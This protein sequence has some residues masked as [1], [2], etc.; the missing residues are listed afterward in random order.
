MVEIKCEFLKSKLV[1]EKEMVNLRKRWMVLFWEIKKVP[2]LAK[3]D[4]EL[5]NQ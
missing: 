4:F 1:D 2:L 5:S 3:R